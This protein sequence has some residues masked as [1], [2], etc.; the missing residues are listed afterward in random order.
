MKKVHLLLFS[1]AIIAVIAT[2]NAEAQDPGSLDRRISMLEQRFFRLESSMTRLEQVISAQRSIPAPS[3]RDQDVLL[4][5][6]EL[7]GLKLR[8]NEIECGLVKLDERTTPASA[9]KNDND[10]CRLNP[11]SPV[12]LSTRP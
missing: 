7:E 2:I 6:Q 8:M 5:R 4:M 9:R 12:R 3:G 1:I 11:N 10:Q